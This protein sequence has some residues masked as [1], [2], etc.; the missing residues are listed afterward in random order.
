[1]RAAATLPTPVR[2]RDCI[3]VAARSQQDSKCVL[4]KW[5]AL[6][7]HCVC[8][9][10]KFICKDPNNSKAQDFVKGVASQPNSICTGEPSPAT[11]SAS[12]QWGAGGV[13]RE[14]KHF[15]GVVSV[16]TS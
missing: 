1:M 9:R 16:A 13:R 6:A 14:T 7:Y 5:A 11:D 8:F 2:V 3:A 4:G 15:M 12:A 10:G